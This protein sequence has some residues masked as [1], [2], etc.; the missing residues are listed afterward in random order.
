MLKTYK[1]VSQSSEV[2]ATRTSI[3]N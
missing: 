2:L 1:Y 3:Y